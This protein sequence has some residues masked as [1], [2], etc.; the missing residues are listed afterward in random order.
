MVVTEGYLYHQLTRPSDKPAWRCNL[1]RIADFL[2]QE[3][4]EMR[5]TAEVIRS[6]CEVLSSADSTQRKDITQMLFV[7]AQE[8]AV[9]HGR[10]RT[11]VRAVLKT[12]ISALSAFLQSPREP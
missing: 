1:E 5:K 2:D 12:R 3:A 11:A 4:A 6:L 8:A 9:I 10:I 7:Q